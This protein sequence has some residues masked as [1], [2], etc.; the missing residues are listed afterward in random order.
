[1]ESPRVCVIH[2][3]PAVRETLAIVLS[4]GYAVE[5]LSPEEF[6]H[7]PSAA[8]ACVALI[9]GDDCVLG[10]TA[11][12]FTA[13]AP[14][15]WLQTGQTAPPFAS[16]QWAT[17]SPA[18]EPQ[19]LRAKLHMLL[20]SSTAGRPVSGAQLSIDYPVI[21]KEAGLL[22]QR[23]G[24][25][26]LPVLLCGAV[27]TGKVRLARAI[28]A[29][30]QPGRFVQLSA[31]ACTRSAL[32][33]TA[34]LA[35]GNLT[36]LVSD[37]AEI[38]TE[39]QQVLRE[40]LDCGGVHSDAG[41][42]SVRLI[43]TTAA[44][45]EDLARLSS[46]GK[47]LFYRLSV[48]PI[49]LPRLRER[50]AD[51]PTLVE[52]LSN[53][54]TQSL[55]RTPVEF[56]RRA[57]ERLERYLWFGNLAELETVLT[58][59]LALVQRDTIDQDDLLFG[60]GRLTLH[61]ANTDHPRAPKP[62]SAPPSIETVDLVINELAHEFKNPM[63]MIKT[64]SQHLERL[65]QDDDGRQQVSRLTNEAVA[66]MD[67]ALDNLLQFSRFRAPVPENI[68]L[69]ALLTSC[70]TDLSPLLTERR[71]ALNFQ[72]A[73]FAPVFVDA[74]Q[75]VHAF[76]NLLRVIIRDLDEGETITI[77]ALGAPTG[78]AFEFA[79]KHKSTA[80]KLASMLDHSQAE[81][82][83]PLGL[84]FARAL[85]ERNGGQL[86]SLNAGQQTTITVSLPSQE[87][88]P[89]DDRRTVRSNGKTASLNR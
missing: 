50:V 66:R 62:V 49:I 26:L 64:V 87:S 2:S 80:G 14:V 27:G 30:G 24:H 4:D 63:V 52:H 83:A 36:L 51:I 72:P 29:L 76:E 20:E 69:N 43:C 3:S 19:E 35:A 34:G 56:T 44:T 8:R 81:P 67:R 5:C 65:L 53:E 40:I 33:Q 88:L 78:A 61:Q 47:D 89:P 12:R 55:A 84:V 22:A 6:R 23:A 18:F 11:S 82:E 39:S 15:L 73:D 48:L 54:L 85:V 16:P 10:D 13:S 21:P 57:M 37:L 42:H 75:L 74:A 59:T 77:R 7:K 25:T 41:W 46:F 70:L 58:R 38:G 17:L 68:G 71:L 28:H 32:V 79:S 1:M 45:L 86:E 31:S 9:V 60:Y